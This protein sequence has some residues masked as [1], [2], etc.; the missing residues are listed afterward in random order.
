MRSPTMTTM[1]ML[2]L[3]SAFCYVCV[4]EKG[5][6][7]L[8]S[9]LIMSQVINYIWAAMRSKHSVKSNGFLGLTT[10]FERILDMNIFSRNCNSAVIAVW[11]KNSNWKNAPKSDLSHSK[12]LKD[13]YEKWWVSL[14]PNFSLMCRRW[15]VNTN[16]NLNQFA[17]RFGFLS[18]LYQISK[19]AMTTARAAVC[20]DEL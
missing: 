12:H 17:I 13:F 20:A 18:T 1:M 3:N 10:T 16:T 6:R 14:L 2:S 11:L 5:C 19:V 7:E 8:S 9:T 15:Q 4:A